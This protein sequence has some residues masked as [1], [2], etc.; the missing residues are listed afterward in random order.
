MS[1]SVPMSSSARVWPADDPNAGGLHALWYRANVS[2]AALTIQRCEDCGQWRHPA[3][4]RCARCHS[5]QWSFVLIDP[6]ARLVE[7]TVTHRALHP[8]FADVVPHAIGV[9]ALDAGPQMLVVVRTDDPAVLRNGDAVTVLVNIR[10][11]PYAV[12]STAPTSS[13]GQ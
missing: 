3:R 7:R 2:A 6:E 12:L 11:V 4:Y 8:S 9:A 13:A 5:A 10:G 1:A